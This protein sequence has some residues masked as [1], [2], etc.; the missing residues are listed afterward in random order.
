[1]KALGCHKIFVSAIQTSDRQY[2]ITATI[3]QS[4]VAAASTPASYLEGTGFKPWPT[5][6]GLL[7]GFP[8]FHCANSV[9]NLNRPRSVFFISF[10]INYSLITLPFYSMYSLGYLQLRQINHLFNTPAKNGDRIVGF[11]Q[12]SKFSKSFRLLCWFYN[13]RRLADLNYIYEVHPG[14][15][16]SHLLWNRN[17]NIWRYSVTQTDVILFPT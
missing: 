1:M 17:N 6:W 3:Y 2:I 12:N 11:R 15:F 4:N 14:T 7:H 8:W 16:W 13:R 5:H 9:T 10:S